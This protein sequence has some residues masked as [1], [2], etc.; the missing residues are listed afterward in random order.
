MIISLS[1]FS[2]PFINTLPLVPRVRATLLH[3][4]IIPPAHAHLA[5]LCWQPAVPISWPATR[6]CIS[7]TSLPRRR[8]LKPRGSAV[9]APQATPTTTDAAVT[10]LENSS[11]EQGHPTL[12]YPRTLDDEY[13]LCQELSKGGNG[14]VRIAC[15]RRT[16]VEYACKSIP[17]VCGW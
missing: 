9:Y 3:Y 7:T 11:N 10:K 4:P 12:G 13:L 5:H 16:G 6:A 1:S 8:P 17:K 15:N 14:T 2:T